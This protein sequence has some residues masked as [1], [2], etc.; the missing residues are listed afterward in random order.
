MS[1]T[2]EIGMP[3]ALGA[4]RAHIRGVTIGRTAALAAAGLAVGL[5]GAAAAT[6]LLRAMLFQ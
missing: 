1:R 6:R 4:T 5:A 2:R 3:T